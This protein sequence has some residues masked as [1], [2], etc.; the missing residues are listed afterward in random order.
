MKHFI[1]KLHEFKLKF[2]Y[3]TYIKMYVR[4]ATFHS[5]SQ[6]FILPNSPLNLNI[7]S[8]AQK[9]ILPTKKKNYQQPAKFNLKTYINMHIKAA[10]LQ[11]THY[12]TAPKTSHI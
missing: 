11:S 10:Q 8:L 12:T 5:D 4:M 3:N 6:I 7:S 1:N 2:N 9:K